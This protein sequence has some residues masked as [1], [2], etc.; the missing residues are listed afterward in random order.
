M[1]ALPAFRIEW[2]DDLPLL[3]AQLERLRLR[4]LLDRYFPVHG[5]WRGISLGW[6]TVLWLTHLLS[7]GDHRLNKDQGPDCPQLKVNLA[8]L[9]T[10]GLPLVTTV[11]AGNE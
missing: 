5:N 7:E 8:T 9:D 6:V 4:E 10:L 2:I 3:L 1:S 11:V